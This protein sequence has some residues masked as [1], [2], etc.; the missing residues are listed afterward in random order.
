MAISF[1]VALLPEVGR[2]DSFGKAH[3]NIG[4]PTETTSCSTV[5]SSSSVAL[6]AE[7]IVPFD[8]VTEGSFSGVS[9]LPQFQ[10]KAYLVST[11]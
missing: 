7:G 8:R 11:R 1:S 4:E 9:D 2:S 3:E 5:C 10:Q 6:A